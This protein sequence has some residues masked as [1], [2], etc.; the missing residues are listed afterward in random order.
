MITDDFDYLAPGG[1]SFTLTSGLIACLTDKSRVLEI[2]CG[3]GEASCAIAQK[4]GCRVEGFDIDRGL[5]S[6]ASDKALDTGVGEIVKFEVRDGTK[7]DFGT[8]QYDL[9]VAE[10]GALTYVDREK[11]VR[12]C[13]E[14]LKDGSYLAVTDLIYLREDVPPE[15]REVYE[16]NGTFR[17]LNE[18]G[19]RRLL[20]QHGFEIVH[21]S[22]VPQSA[23]DRYYMSMSR[24]IRKPDFGF[25]EEFRQAMAR[26]IDVYY[27]KN[28]MFYVGYI[29]IVAR[30]A[31]DKAVGQGPED[32]RIPMFGSMLG[33]EPVVAPAKKGK[34][35]AKKSKSSARR[36]S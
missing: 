22:M 17:F 14:L 32:L 31:R 19:Y 5:I 20:E 24:L 10:G 35:S 26:E 15:I 36:K 9:I 21:L 4:F 28:A 25:P 13:A 30:M 29:Y 33:N 8:G 18:I 12:R 11:G 23:W 16:E 3:K 34:A 27:A 6:Y 7:M 1:R 2:A